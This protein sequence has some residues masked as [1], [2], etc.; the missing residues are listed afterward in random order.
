MVIEAIDCEPIEGL[1]DELDAKAED[2][3]L[4][5]PSQR[6]R[7][8]P[9]YPFRAAC[10][11]LSPSAGETNSAKLGGHTRNLS[12]GG[13]GL[14]VRGVFSTGTVL[15]IQVAPAGREPVFMAG[16]VRFCRYAGRGY[17]E[18][19]VELLAARPEPIR[20]RQA[21]VPS[22]LLEELRSCDDSN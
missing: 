17:R 14:L 4:L 16:V 2:E 18:I 22:E 5:A 10:T 21:G 1:I 12:R 15:E 19:G 13:L 7:Q 6:R 3:H 8:C 20:S 11:I 9:R